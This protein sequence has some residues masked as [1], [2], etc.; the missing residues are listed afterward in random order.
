M[1]PPLP[2]GV[3]MGPIAPADAGTDAG[4]QTGYLLATVTRL[5]SLERR[6][7]VVADSNGGAST[8]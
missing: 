6:R 1:A 3:T 5:E 2:F 8:S 7:E 4:V